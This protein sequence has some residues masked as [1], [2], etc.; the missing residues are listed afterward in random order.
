MTAWDGWELERWILLFALAMYGGMWMQVFLFHSRARFE[1]L[2]MFGPV[3]FTP[4]TIVLGA[5]ALIE[6]EGIWGWIALALLAG[7][8]ALALVGLTFHLRGVH[9]RFGGFSLANL[10]QG[11]PP[12]MPVAYGMTGVLGVI[13]LTWEAGAW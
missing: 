4:I 9:R 7:S 3:V 1:F 2:A 6:R 11:P 5:I 8:V 12:F 10:I 13:G